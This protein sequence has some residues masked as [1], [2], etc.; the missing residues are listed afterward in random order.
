MIGA[1][2]RLLLFQLAGE[3]LAQALQL[4]VPGPVLGMA[5]LF[6]MLVWRGHTPQPLARAAQG[7]LANLPLLFVPAGVGVMVHVSRI[8]DEG[9]SILLSL[10]VSTLAT[11]LVSGWVLQRLSRGRGER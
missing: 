1:F 7:V 4:P 2:T 5:L 9:G 8:V 10:V 6:A 3:I 11:L